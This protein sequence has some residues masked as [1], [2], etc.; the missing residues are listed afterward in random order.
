MG[1]PTTRVPDWTP[2]QD[3]TRDIGATGSEHRQFVFVENRGEEEGC[4]DFI[5]SLSGNANTFVPAAQQ[6]AVEPD[7]EQ[8]YP[9]EDWEEGQPEN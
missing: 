3:N 8:E 6:T 5:Y 2:D 1:E 4:G 9:Q 7:E